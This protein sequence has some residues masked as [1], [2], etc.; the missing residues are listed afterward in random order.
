MERPLRPSS[1]GRAPAGQHGVAN[2]ARGEPSVFRRCAKDESHPRASKFGAA[3]E[4]FARAGCARSRPGPAQ[5]CSQCGLARA[6]SRSRREVGPACCRPQ[7]PCSSPTAA[8]STDTHPAPARRSRARRSA[9][10]PPRAPSDARRRPGSL[11]PPPPA[12][13]P[14]F[15]TLLRR[16]TASGPPART[17]CPRC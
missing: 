2:L 5:L 6:S 16:P 10:H 14:T 1:P 7:R 3:R 4:R 17:G 11:S 8:L 13:P 9:A 15:P 12:A